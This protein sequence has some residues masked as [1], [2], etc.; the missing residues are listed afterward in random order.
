MTDLDRAGCILQLYYSVQ[1]FHMRIIG[2]L[3][4]LIAPFIGLIIMYFI[5]G[6]HQGFGSFVQSLFRLP[7]MAGKV[8]TLS[9][10]IN[11]L[12]FAVFTSLRGERKK[13]G[14]EVSIGIFI[15]TML[16]VVAIVIIK[17]IW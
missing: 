14:D 15:A 11:L 12:P 10:L 8:F 16:Y 9:L 5:W 3:S 7:G 17:Y 4:G 6:S 2:F 13:M 1:Y